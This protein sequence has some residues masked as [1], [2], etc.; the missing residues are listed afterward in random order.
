VRYSGVSTYKNQSIRN[1]KN[2]V[3]IS[4]NF[5]NFYVCSKT[6]YPVAGRDMHVDSLTEEVFNEM[7][8]YSIFCCREQASESSESWR[9]YINVGARIALC[10]RLDDWGFES[11]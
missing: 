11:R 5:C 6:D 10:Y 7:C 4:N 3:Y 9:P 8:S 2:D 1:K